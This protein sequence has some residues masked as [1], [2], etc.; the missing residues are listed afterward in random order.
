[1][2]L[3]PLKGMEQLCQSDEDLQTRNLFVD[4]VIG[5]EQAVVCIEVIAERNGLEGICHGIGGEGAEWLFVLWVWCPVVLR[6]REIER[7]I[8]KRIW[9]SG[10]ISMCI[11][12]ATEWRDRYRSQNTDRLEN[13]HSGG[14]ERHCHRVCDEMKMDRMQGMESCIS[15]I[16]T[17]GRDAWDQ[18][19]LPI[20]IQ[21]RYQTV[22]CRFARQMVIV[23]N[24]FGEVCLRIERRRYVYGKVTHRPLDT[25]WPCVEATDF[26]IK[27]QNHSSE[28]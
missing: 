10:N 24:H 17:S 14:T 5:N 23:D 16:R 3:G 18:A 26:S 2:F 20:A 25:S 9:R 19:F 27:A 8:L 22:W 6:E 11:N 28:N 12:R 4:E 1:M 13:R 15:C 21:P 7:D